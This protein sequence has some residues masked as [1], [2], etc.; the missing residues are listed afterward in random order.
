MDR[1]FL[2]K[3]N[4]RW[5]AR[6]TLGVI[7]VPMHSVNA[8]NDVVMSHSVPENSCG[9][10]GLL[11][12]GLQIWTAIPFLVR[13]AWCKVSNFDMHCLLL[14]HLGGYQDLLEGNF[15]TRLGDILSFNIRNMNK[16]GLFCFIWYNKAMSFLSTK[17]FY[18]PFVDWSNFSP[19]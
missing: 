3:N 1:K 9:A 5:L 17:L 11:G 19:F 7:T 13:D 15:I 6:C 16:D 18:F 4:M 10:Y 8:A 14:L 2:K 12:V